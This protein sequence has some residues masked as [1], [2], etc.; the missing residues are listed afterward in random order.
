MYRKS[1]KNLL[2]CNISSTCPHN[3]MKFG[4]VT[5]EIGWWVGDTQQISTGFASWLR[6]CTDVAQRKSTKVCTMFGRLLGRYTIYTFWRALAP[7]RN[8]PGA[9]FTLR[10]SLAFSY[11][12]RV[13]ARHSSSGREP[14]FAV[15]SRGRQLYSA[16]RPSRFTSTNIVVTR[17]LGYPRH[18][19]H[20]L[21]WKRTCW[22]VKASQIPLR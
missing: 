11:I 10:L 14:N 7:W 15:F 9:I 19:R 17:L 5:T 12:V 3:K 20:M 4:P 18:L 2:N 13:T 6:Y 21:V 8:L 16:G 1:K 22:L